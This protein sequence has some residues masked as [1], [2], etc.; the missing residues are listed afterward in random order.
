MK[1]ETLK[2]F[3]NKQETGHLS[4]ENEQFIFN[5]TEDASCVVSLTM[6]VRKAS[7]NSKVLHQRVSI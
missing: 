5:Y 3:I 4:Y 6:P 1:E 7:W 2:L